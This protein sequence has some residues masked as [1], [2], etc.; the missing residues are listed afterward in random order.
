LD[1]EGLLLHTK[2]TPQALRIAYPDRVWD[3][4]IL[5]E[6]PAGPPRTNPQDAAVRIQRAQ[7]GASERQST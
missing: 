3:S 4:T 5:E 7:V 2:N 1:K 6:P